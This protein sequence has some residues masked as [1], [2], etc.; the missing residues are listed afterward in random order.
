MKRIVATTSTS[1]LDYYEH[2]YDIRTI[3]IKIDMGDH[4][5]KD[6]GTEIKADEFFKKM[7]E[8]P[9][10]VPRTSQPS[11]GE[12]IEFFEGLADEGYEECIVTTI[13][14]K[15]SG[16]FNGIS[17]AAEMLE[18]RIKIIPFDTKTV[19]FNE[20][21]FALEASRMIKE[22]ASTEDILARLDFLQK[23]VRI[24]F[25]VDSLECLVKNGRLSGAA[26]LLGKLLK[27]KPLLE[28]EPDGTIQAIEKIRTTKKALE[29]LCDYFKE[30]TNGHNYYAYI[31]Y[32]GTE[33]KDFFVN[34]LKESL[35]LENLDERPCSP[36][37]GCHV[38]P[39]A[40]G[41]G[42]MLKD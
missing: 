19:C 1:C 3:R 13:S 24:F 42:I 28:V 9:H 2:E 36:V 41:L 17:Q 39:Q 22:G 30:Y 23:N 8:D 25:A 15:L 14:S 35:G 6:D 29:T 37:V 12:L 31:V 18:D 10:L 34:V 26:G 33:L 40:I 27:I 38:G 5:F 16:T 32:T 20:G 21:F 11:L 4:N 7:N